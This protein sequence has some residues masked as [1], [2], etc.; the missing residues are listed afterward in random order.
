MEYLK[1]YDITDNEIFKLKDRYNDGIIQFIE[2]NR[3]YIEEKL[4]YL[5]NEKFVLLYEIMYNN[6]KIFLKKFLS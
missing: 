2:N 6:I 4:D 1:K 3:E 5:Q